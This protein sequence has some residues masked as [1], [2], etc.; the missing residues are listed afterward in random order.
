MGR[1]RITKSD[2]SEKEVIENKSAIKAVEFPN[3]EFST[4]E[5]LFEHLSENEKDLISLKTSAI[6]YSDNCKFDLSPDDGETKEIKGLEVGKIAA[7]INTTNFIDSHNDVHI[8]KI[9]NRS[10]KAQKG[11]IYYVADHALKL[12]SVIA[13]P[14]DVE[15]SVQTLSWKELGQKFEGNTDALIYIVPIDRIKNEKALEVIKYKI[16]I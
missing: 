5:D 7:I 11:K 15:I 4:K 12:D 1:R 14:K 16:D 13:F 6:K 9:W 8:P 10:L 3:K 2:D